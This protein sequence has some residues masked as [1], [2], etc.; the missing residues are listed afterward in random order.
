MY[1]QILVLPRDVIGNVSVNATAAKAHGVIAV[2][3]ER[4]VTAPNPQVQPRRKCITR[5]LQT[6]IVC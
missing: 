4:D 1:F 2:A 5:I 3:P 6:D